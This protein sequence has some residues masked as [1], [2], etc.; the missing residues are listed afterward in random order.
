MNIKDVKRAE[1]LEELELQ[2]FDKKERDKIK[3]KKEVNVTTIIGIV[4]CVLLL[5]ILIFNIILLVQSFVNEDEVPS[6]GGYSPMVVMTDSMSPEILSGDLIIVKVVDPSEINEN[7]IISFFDPASKTGTAV[8]T[9]RV[10]SIEYIDGEIF[11][12]TKGDFNN[13][14]DED[15]VPADNLVG[16][17]QSRISGLGNVVLFM[18][19]IPGLIIGIGVP[20]VLLIGYD[21][22]RRKGMEEE[23]AR[24]RDKLLQELE[25]LRKEKENK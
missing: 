8:V 10:I 19:T 20:L 25:A 17:Y 16:L 14:A 21:M 7:D 3:K 4:A 22:L 12:E 5:P 15:L 23:Q 1:A 9:H 6:V 2:E 13:D 24:E 18:Q 11:F